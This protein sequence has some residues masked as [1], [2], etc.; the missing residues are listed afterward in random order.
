MLILKRPFILSAAE[1]PNSIAAMKTML[2]ELFSRLLHSQGLSGVIASQYTDD[3]T[4]R[5]RVGESA[6]GTVSTPGFQAC[7]DTG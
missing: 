5:M 6:G 3:R 2:E 1:H 4:V 7:C